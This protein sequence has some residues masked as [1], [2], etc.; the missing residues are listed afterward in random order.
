MRK[1]TV[2]L[3]VICLVVSSFSV[4]AVSSVSAQAGYK[5]SVPQFTVELVDSSYDVSP[6]STT[7]PYT[8]VTSTFPGYRVN[9]KSIE[10]TIKNQPFTAYIGEND[11]SGLYGPNGQEFNLYYQVVVKGSF[12]ED[13]RSFGDWCAIQSNSGYTVVSSPVEYAAGSQLDFKVKAV[14]GYKYNTIYGSLAG[15][16]IPGPVWGV[17]I[18]EQGDWSSVKTF[19]IPGSPLQT[20]TF[21]PVTSDGNGQTQ[22]PSQTQ[23]PNSIFSN[24]LFTLGIGVLLGGV[25]IVVVMMIFKRHLKAQ[26]CANNSIQTNSC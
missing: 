9:Q 5:P 21:P 3:L 11:N 7:D 19:T 6:S 15:M 26:T 17:S 14:V 2:F 12:G 13:W 10:I 1:Y 16:H 18:T 20:A 23:P 25:V 8:G 24:P 22:Y 4:L